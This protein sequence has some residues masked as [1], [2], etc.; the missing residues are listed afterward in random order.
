M[1]KIKVSLPNEKNN[2]NINDFV[3]NENNTYKNF[4]FYVN[5]DIE[6][7]DYWFVVENIIKNSEETKINRNNIIYLNYETSYPKDYFITKYMR[8]YLDQFSFKYGCYNDFSDNYISSYPFQPWLIN[9]SQNSSLES[10]SDRDYEYLRNLNSIE[11]TKNLSVICSTKK[12]T[13]DHAARLK[14][15]EKLQEH[16]NKDLDWFG[17]GKK[18]IDQKW[19]GISKYKYHIV[20]ENESRNNLISEKLYDSYLGLSYP[21]YFGAPNLGEY[22][23]KYSFSFI[24]IFNISESIEIIEK[25]IENNLY[26]KNFDDLVKSKNIVLDKFNLFR[27]MVAIIEDRPLENLS[28]EKSQNK[29]HSV[30][31]FWKKDVGLKEKTKHHIK[32]KL[33]LNVRNY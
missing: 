10:K 11:K 3:D 16:F 27:R 25:G 1:Y 24:D 6:E 15:V 18:N 7:A 30:G 5:Q 13:D 22:F 2:L 23:P 17:T 9:S 21:F 20:L 28:L 19:E 8:N 4:K 33:R 29:I 32:R 14:F 31:T 12:V 26:E